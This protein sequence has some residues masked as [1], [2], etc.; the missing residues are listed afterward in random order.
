MPAHGILDQ[1]IVPLAQFV[2]EEGDAGVAIAVETDDAGRHPPSGL[3]ARRRAS[4]RSRRC[5]RRSRCTT[6]ERPTTEP[7]CRRSCA[8]RRPARS[9]ARERHATRSDRGRDRL[10]HTVSSSRRVARGDAPPIHRRASRVRRTGRG[11]YR[12][13][14]IP[15]AR[16][17]VVGLAPAAHGGNR[18]GRVFTGD[19]SGDFLFPALFEAGF[20]NQP[21]S[22]GIGD[23]LALRDLFV[24]RGESL[25][26]AGQ[27][28]D[29]AGARQLP[30]LPGRGAAR[31]DGRA[32]DRVPWLVRVGRRSARAR[33][34]GPRGKA[35]AKVRP[36]RR[37]R[38]WVRMC[39]SARTTRASRTRSPA[40]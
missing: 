39:S 21:T 33:R 16:V 35:T 19:R 8:E 22:I 38:W 13:S 25:R 34:A 37:R 1:G 14:A 12:A 6:S 26:A 2:D 31:A 7:S 23:G 18:T 36:P 9:V 32:R 27:Q 24:C 15:Q 29:A 28:A 20:A 17:L 4:R 10:V 11:R 40:N 30:A 3:R 5:C